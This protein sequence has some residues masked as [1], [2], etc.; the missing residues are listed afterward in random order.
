MYTYKLTYPLQITK[1]GVLANNILV[2]LIAFKASLSGESQ[3]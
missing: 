1:S 3:E 2:A